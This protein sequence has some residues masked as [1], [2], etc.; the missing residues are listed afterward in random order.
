MKNSEFT[1]G[2]VAAAA[3]AGDY[4]STSAHPFRLDD[5]VLA[6]LN[7]RAKKPRRNKKKLQDPELTWTAGFF[8]ALAEIHR[9]SHNSSSVCEVVHNAGLTLDAAKA[10]GVDSFDLRELKRAGLKLSVRKRRRGAR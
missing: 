1:R 9:L 10:A 5:C 4:N 8:I 3:V 2:A 7:I 6:K